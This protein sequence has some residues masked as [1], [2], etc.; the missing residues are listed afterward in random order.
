MENEKTKIILFFANYRYNP[1][2]NELQIKES[3]ALAAEE[4]TKRLR[5]LHE[6]LKK[7]A[8]FVNLI[9]GRYYDKRHEDIPLWKE[10]DKVY[11]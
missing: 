3:I 9:I 11:L 5:S 4:S 7:D 6:Q 8:E 1:T 10:G 2:I